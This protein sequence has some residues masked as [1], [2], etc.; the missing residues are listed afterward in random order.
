MCNWKDTEQPINEAPLDTTY[1]FLEALTVPQLIE[2]GIVFAESII[3]TYTD[4]NPR[5][6]TAYGDDRVEYLAFL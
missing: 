2:L 6:C 5:T 3:T 1:T 4:E